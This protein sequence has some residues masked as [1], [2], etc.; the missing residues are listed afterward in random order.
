M[1]LI[2]HVAIVTVDKIWLE[3]VNIIGCEV[4]N[5][6]RVVKLGGTSV[7][8]LES[9]IGQKDQSK[10]SVPFLFVSQ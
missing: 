3:Q 7:F 8:A 2:I 1:I 9:G 6:K 4:G 5:W 10:I